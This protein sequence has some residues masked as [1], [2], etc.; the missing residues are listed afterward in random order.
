[1]CN[2]LGCKFEPRNTKLAC[3]NHEVNTSAALPRSILKAAAPNAILSSSRIKKKKHI[4]LF[5]F[6]PAAA[7]PPAWCCPCR[8]ST[9][10]FPCPVLGSSSAPEEAGLSRASSTL[11]QQDVAPGA[12]QSPSAINQGATP[13]LGFQRRLNRWK[14]GRFG[15]WIPQRTLVTRNF[16]RHWSETKQEMGAEFQTLT[17]ALIQV[18]KKYRN[19][20]C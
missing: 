6:L 4:Y 3:F 12:Y 19:K 5:C 9:T 10:R 7:V 14:W 11:P 16:H 18:T 15:P 13:Q 2:T 8:Q 20:R 1:M 17:S